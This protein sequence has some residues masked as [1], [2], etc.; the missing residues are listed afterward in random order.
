MLFWDLCT[1]LEYDPFHPNNH[2]TPHP[3][4]EFPDTHQA[5]FDEAFLVFR[6]E[7]KQRVIRLLQ[8]TF[9]ADFVP[10]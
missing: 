8:V 1:G 9:F 5:P 3:D 7:E 10:H 6:L 2:V 4:P